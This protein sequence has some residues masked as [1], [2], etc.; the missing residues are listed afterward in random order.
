MKNLVTTR[1]NE[2]IQ[3]FPIV[4]KLLNHPLAG[5]LFLPLRIWLGY[6]WLEA[7]LHKLQTPAWMATGEALKGFWTKAI[8]IPATG[9]PAISFGWYRAFLQFLLDTGSYTW[10]AKLISVGEFLVGI[11]LILG[12]FTG[13]AAFFGG[14]MNWNFMMAGSA[15]VNPLYL[16]V[17]ILLIVAWKISGYFG[18]DY[19]L[20]PWSGTLYSQKVEPIKQ[21]PA[22]APEGAG[23]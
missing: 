12:M 20:I 14:F 10:F 22:R 6:Q 23:D 3:N 2:A 13:I 4:N 9:N 19:F 18:L 11:A 5:L 8:A 15:S 1:N 16:A 17:S 7:G 21:F